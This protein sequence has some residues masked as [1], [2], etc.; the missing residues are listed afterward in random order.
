MARRP[1]RRDT[2]GALS[3]DNYVISIR[4]K[5]AAERYFRDENGWLK[6]STRG[7]QFRATAEQVLNHLLPALVQLKPVTVEVEYRYGAETRRR[8][9]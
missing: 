9:C 5:S 4:T 2:L 8:E 7:R 1:A 3:N 6:E